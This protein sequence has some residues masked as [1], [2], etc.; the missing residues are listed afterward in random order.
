MLANFRRQ[1]LQAQIQIIRPQLDIFFA[2]SAVNH[3]VAV[4]LGD[5]DT[6][7][8]LAGLGE[9]FLD[10]GDISVDLRH[11]LIGRTIAL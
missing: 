6:A 4:L 7:S 8:L 10:P 3:M 5:N 2:R 11:H 1:G 9:V